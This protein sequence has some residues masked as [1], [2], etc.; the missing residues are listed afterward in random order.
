MQCELL[1]KYMAF[2]LLDNLREL[3]T[4]KER[5]S[6]GGVEW[7]IPDE[8]K[9]KLREILNLG[10]DI[11]E[12]E[13]YLIADRIGNVLE[14]VIW[15]PE[16][17][18][19][20][21]FRQINVQSVSTERLNGDLVERRVSRSSKTEREGLTRQLKRNLIKYDQN[22]IMLVYGH[23]HPQSPIETRTLRYSET[24]LTVPRS[25]NSMLQYFGV[26]A[27]AEHFA[28]AQ[29]SGSRSQMVINPIS[30]MVDV[31]LMGAK[32]ASREFGTVQILNLDK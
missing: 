25:I 3:F 12:H 8:G 26:D 10:A 1:S 19:D 31:A 28:L 21:L 4:F 18:D 23:T 11:G 15:E 14:T 30:E 16:S 27:K 6:N 24:D 22:Q 7:S 9:G 5:T 20:E 17:E 29:M 13:F 2:R 32:K